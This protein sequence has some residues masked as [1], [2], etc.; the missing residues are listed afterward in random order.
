[1]P[2]I[3]RRGDQRDGRRVFLHR[4]T[5]G[6][7]REKRK[8]AAY[9]DEDGAGDQRHVEAGN[10]QDVR[11]A[12]LAQV[13]VDRFGDAGA[14]ARDQRRGDFGLGAVENGAHPRGDV[15]ADAFEAQ[16]QRFAP[17]QRRGRRRDHRVAQEKAD[18]P[19]AVVIAVIGEVVA[20]RP[21]RAGWWHQPCDADDRHAELQV[22]RHV[23]RGEPNAVGRVAQFRPGG[24][25]HVDGQPGAPRRLMFDPHDPPRDLAADLRAHHRRVGA[26]SFQTGS[27]HACHC[28]QRGEDGEGQRRP[29]L[30]E[31]CHDDEHADDRADQQERRLE[32]QRAIDDHAERHRN[33]DQDE[34]RSAVALVRN[35]PGGGLADGKR[36]RGDVPPR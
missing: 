10:R 3:E 34:A 36:A 29:G 9:G 5:R 8:A 1:M 28:G 11:E 6:E 18:R 27:T 21:H 4:P 16:L 30:Q 17:A 23:S 7:D 33:R 24:R 12:R 2:E 15:E 32:G 31:M 35:R 20:A 26:P 14:H 13:L 19:D 22:G 25:D